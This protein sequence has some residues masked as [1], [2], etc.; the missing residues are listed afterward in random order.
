MMQH[1]TALK[2]VLR[3]LSGTRLHG[4]TYGNVLDHPKHFLGYTDTVF[5]NTDDQKS[6][7]QLVDLD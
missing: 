6:T 5:V 3:Y 7:L 4:I 2:R 1:V